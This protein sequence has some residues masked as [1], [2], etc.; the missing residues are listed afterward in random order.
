MTNRISRKNRITTFAFLLATLL[1]SCQVAKPSPFPTISEVTVLNGERE[2]FGYYAVSLDGLS[3]YSNYGGKMDAQSGKLM[4]RVGNYVCTRNGPLRLSPNERYLSGS[5]NATGMGIYDIQ[6]GKCYQP[7]NAIQLNPVESWSPESNRF[8]LAQSRIIMD[9]PSFQ[10]VPYPLDYPF[11]FKT[12]KNVYGHNN[13]L[14]DR[15]TNLP[16]AEAAAGCDG[17]LYTNDPEFPNL[18]AKS[19]LEIRSLDVPALR[20]TTTPI[21][22]RLLTFDWITGVSY[23]IFDPTGEYIL[24]AVEERTLP[25]T[26]KQEMSPQQKYEYYYNEKYVVDTVL[27]LVRWRTKEHVELLRLSE[28]GKVQNYAI[29]SDMSWSADGSTI[30]VPRKNA[31]PLVIRL[32]YP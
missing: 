25:P 27:M 29:L 28:Y 9:F 13:I 5:N 4:G 6:A 17:C 2:S 22:E 10:Q 21:R 14:W 23:P 3:Y 8:V 18:Q 11:D 30:F 1:S 12:F 26:P 15:D 20:E 32:T 24:V 31:P 7:E 19:Y 16:I